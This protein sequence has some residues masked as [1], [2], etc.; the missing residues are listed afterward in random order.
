MPNPPTNTPTTQRGGDPINP[1]ISR[2][3]W[4]AWRELLQGHGNA[5]AVAGTG[6]GRGT[7]V[8]AWDFISRPM[9]RAEVANLVAW[10]VMVSEVTGAELEAVTKAQGF[11]LRL[12][13]ELETPAAVCGECGGKLGPVCTSCG[14]AFP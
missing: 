10:L 3:R 7:L 9:G 13:L 2:Q 5:F 12:A 4:E 6:D 14:R 8:L 11:P 1:L